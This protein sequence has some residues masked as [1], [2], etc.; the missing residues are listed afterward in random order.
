MTAG[1]TRPMKLNLSLGQALIDFNK[2]TPAD[3]IG[4]YG[5]FL[6]TIIG[7]IQCLKFIVQKI[8]AR[9][10]RAKFQTDLYL[11]RK[12]DRNTKEVHPI[13]VVLLANL[14]FERIALKTLEYQ[15]IAEKGG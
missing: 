11:L 3:W 1:E 15:G 5:A 13:V 9:K 8:R 10:E 4:I 14:G 2:N 6:A 7:L 12:V